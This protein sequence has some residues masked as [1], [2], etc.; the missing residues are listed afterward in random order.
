MAYLPAIVAVS[1]YFEKRR[2]LATGIA[3]CGS[4]VG[5]FIFAPLTNAL[6]QEYTW[7]GTVL[8]EAGILLNCI[9][10]GMV[11]RPLN[12]LQTSNRADAEANEE[13]NPMHGVQADTSTMGTK[14]LSMSWTTMEMVVDG[15]ETEAARQERLTNV[16]IAQESRKKSRS[17]SMEFPQTDARNVGRRRQLSE[18]SHRSSLSHTSMTHSVG[19]MARKDVFYTKSLDNI[20]QYRADRDEYIR[21]MT[22]FPEHPEVEED[23]DRG[24]L[25]KIGITEDMRQTITDM[26]DFRLLLDIVFIL[27]AVSNLLTSIGMVVPYIFL[28][29]RGL[30]LGFD[31]NQASLLISVVGISNTIGRVV[32][33]YIADLKC[34]NRLT[35]YNTVLVLCGICSVFSALLWTFPLQMCYSFSFG[36]LMGM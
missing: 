27:F 31:S 3:V 26:M 7:K 8:I 32:F 30:R 36:F 19:P 16:V 9:L 1:F 29:N 14:C 35:L 2:S 11:F 25:A 20:P 21:S 33:G 24:C 10:C 18:S 15:A 17:M 13:E 34:V 5:T 22:S 4:G 12:V 28:P 23:E 6:L